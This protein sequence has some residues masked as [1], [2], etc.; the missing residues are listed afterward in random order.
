MKIRFMLIPIALLLL[1]VLS[2]CGA[3][4]TA[5]AA[6][7]MIEG[8]GH[9]SAQQVK[10]ASELGGKVVEVLVDEGDEIQAGDVLFR[11]DDAI[12]QAQY[13]QA[14][15][16]VLVAQAAVNTAQ[17]QLDAATSQYTLALQGARLQDLQARNAA[18]LVPLPEEFTLPVWYYQKAERIQAIQNEVE[19]AHGDVV[20]EQADLAQELQDASNSDLVAAETSLAAAQATYQIA[21]QTHAQATAANENEIVEEIAQEQLDTALADLERA[22]LDYDRILS[23]TA[24]ADILA[25]RGRVA[26][27]QS[28]Y[29]NALDAQTQLLSGEQSLQVDVA[30]AAVALAEV[31]LAQVEA[32][33]VAAEASLQILEVQLA[34]TVIYAPTS[35]VVLTRNLEIG[36]MI[37]QGGPVMEV[38]DLA[39]VELTVYIS[40]DRYG[41]VK[42]G[43]QVEIAVDSFPDETFVGTIAAIADQAEFTPRNVQTVDGRKSTVFAVKIVLSNPEGKL[44]PGM[45]ADARIRF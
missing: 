29:E 3:F 12:Y 1:L 43:Q 14:Q 18:W 25:A 38:A 5:Q 26:V 39:Q 22:Q 17:A 2:A 27:A 20:Q 36:E 31:G 32:N 4:P 21:L 45:P 19:V 7:N 15:A 40:E 13:R 23:E 30:V 41:Q 6:E 16:G 10:I 8:S 37:A 42:L 28:R 34:K 11:L 35:G 24:S 33:L 9:V 44:K